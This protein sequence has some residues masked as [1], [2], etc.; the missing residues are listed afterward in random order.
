MDIGWA[1]EL[2]SD[3]PAWTEQLGRALGR[4]ARG[5]ELLLLEGELGA[6]KTALVRGL[7]D[8]AGGSA[9]RVKSPSY[10][11]HHQHEG[12]LVVH[13]LDVYF[14]GSALDLERTPVL[15][16]LE[17]GDLVAIEWGRRFADVLPADRLELELEHTGPETRHVR[18]LARGP[19]ATEWLR[20]TQSE[21]D[22]PQ[23]GADATQTEPGGGQPR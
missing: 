12:R 3:S 15:D 19:R 18:I 5:G 23:K 16:F 13:H 11:L 7:V 9:R 21:L 2:H 14:T 20:R 17:R 1:L 8:G 22:S 10:T 6:G 4:E